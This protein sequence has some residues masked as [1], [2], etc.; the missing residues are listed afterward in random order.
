MFRDDSVGRQWRESGMSMTVSP[1]SMSTALPR[2]AVTGAGGAAAVSFIDAVA[3]RNVEL[4]AC[5]IDPYAAGLYLVPSER[6]WIV[7]RGGSP[8]FADHLLARCIEAQV[9]VLVPTAD[10]ELLPLAHR[11]DDFAARGITL[12]LAP[13]ITIERCLDK[14]NLIQACAELCAVPQTSIVDAGFSLG[15]EPRPVRVKPRRGAEAGRWRIVQHADDLAAVPRDGSHLAQEILSGAE[16]SVEVLCDTQGTVRVAVPR[17]RLATE[18]ASASAERVMNDE[19]MQA[20][21]SGVARRLGITFAANV[22][23]REDDH[24]NLKLLDVDPRF[25]RSTALTVLAGVNTPALAL[26]LALARPI[27]PEALEFRETASIRTWH[28]R[29]VEPAEIADLEARARELG[30]A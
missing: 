7:H 30:P 25:S 15:D 16:Y 6:R 4:F 27:D 23:F 24:G 19:R 21:A 28:D 14:W 20:L 13:A 8:R 17:M 9:D 5:D 10:S 12:L 26:D 3:A 29:L 2:V 18:S 1:R 11:R 22:Q